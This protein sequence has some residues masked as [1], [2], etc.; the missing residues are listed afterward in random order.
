MAVV[1]DYYSPEGCHITVNDDCY[2]PPE[3]QQAILKRVSELV[4]REEYRRFME[5][6]LSN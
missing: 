6:Q 3:E 1:K 2:K 5:S 4:L